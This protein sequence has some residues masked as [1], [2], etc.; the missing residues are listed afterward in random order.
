M[1]V[2][3]DNYKTGLVI[4][5]VCTKNAELLNISHTQGRKT[6]WI[7]AVKIVGGWNIKE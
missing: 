6:L 7:K 1:A 5:I 3:S 2:Y 4:N